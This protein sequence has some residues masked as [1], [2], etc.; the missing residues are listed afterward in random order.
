MDDLIVQNTE[1]ASF[2]VISAGHEPT[3]QNPRGTVKAVLNS[4]SDVSEGRQG[5]PAG[6]DGATT[7]HPMALAALADR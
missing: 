3:R 1:M 5:V 4:V 7:G 6:L 2:V